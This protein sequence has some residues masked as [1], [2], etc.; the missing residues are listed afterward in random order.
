MLKTFRIIPISII[1]ILIVVSVALSA[2][3]SGQ[4]LDPTLT[5]TST[6][7]PAPT[8]QSTKDVSISEK[9]SELQTP[10]TEEPT[11]TEENTI[12]TSMEKLSSISSVEEEVESLECVPDKP[13]K[14]H[15][16]YDAAVDHWSKIENAESYRYNVIYVYKSGEQY[17]ENELSLDFVGEYTGLL[18]DDDE[19]HHNDY[20]DTQRFEQS[21]TKLTD[22]RTMKQYETIITGD[23]IWIRLPGQEWLELT[24][25]KPWE[26]S[27][28]PENF[29]PY[30]VGGW[31]AESGT[32]SAGFQAEK[33]LMVQEEEIDGVEVIHRCWKPESYGY[34]A[35]YDV[36]NAHLVH[37]DSLYTYLEDAEVHLWTT[38]DGNQW[39]RLAVK[40]KHIAELYFDYGELFHDPPNDF[41]LWVDIPDIN[42]EINIDPPSE[43]SVFLK[44][45]A[46]PTESSAD[47]QSSLQELPIPE[48]AQLLSDDS[49]FWE[50]LEKDISENG[51]SPDNVW[52]Y[53]PRE[54]LYDSGYFKDEIMT[55]KYQ[56]NW[57]ELP[58]TRMPVY[59]TSQD[60]DSLFS[61]YMQ[62]MQN[63]GWAL[64]DAAFQLGD[65]KY[66]LFF[67]NGLVTVPII[68]EDYPLDKSHIRAIL[69]PDEEQLA[70]IMGYWD[71]Y[72]QENSGLV[73]KFVTAI[74]F[75]EQGTAWIG[76]TAGVAYFDG[77]DWGTFTTSNSDLSSNVVTDLAVGENNRVWIATKEGLNIY[78]GDTWQTFTKN[79]YQLEGLITNIAVGPDGIVWVSSYVG[80]SKFVSGEWE[81][82]GH[83]NEVKTVDI[84][85]SGK[86]WIGTYAG[87]YFLEEGN[88]VEQALYLEDDSAITNN[89]INNLVID[90]KGRVW[91]LSSDL[92]LTLHE[93]EST[94]LFTACGLDGQ[95]YD[96]YTAMTVDGAG[97]VWIFT[98]RTSSGSLCVLEEEE[99]WY[100]YTPIDQ[101]ISVGVGPLSV[102]PSGRIW[103]NTKDGIGILS[104]PIP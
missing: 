94:T 19:Y 20:F 70:A 86:P 22:L 7:M 92:T 1:S 59:E 47:A 81:K 5:P 95:Q 73:E 97:R 71:Q 68:L 56:S 4:P 91:T 29:S 98:F 75:D 90:D 64:E 3:G 50:E 74:E 67:S 87:V 34:E 39:R 6:N 43:E 25:G 46:E 77:H 58:Q 21:H 83:I 88:W 49:G 102:D 60:L 51:P 82:F 33:P 85:S 54:F 24:S 48:D 38:K 103:I 17:A 93:F 45:P 101:T 53:S 61:F 18:P 42:Q 89:D 65:T 8:I 72:T 100:D 104:A 63:L 10:V 35:P 9:Q 28:L 78:D 15:S 69:P 55:D 41:Y 12:E 40:G 23:S 57:Y 13:Q 44:I 37:W 66:F 30:L 32:L 62:E 79:D 76:T 52:P 36:L 96:P 31:L 80:V 99:K 2:C 14:A 11:I 84:D 27:N 26:L 16:F